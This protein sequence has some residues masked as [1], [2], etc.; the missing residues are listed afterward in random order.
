ME[1]NKFIQLWLIIGI[2]AGFAAVIFFVMTYLNNNVLCDLDCRFKNEV[3]LSLIFLSLVGMFIGSITYYFISEKYEK[4]LG[5]LHKDLSSTYKFLNP[6]QRA[7]LKSI[8]SKEG[9]TTQSDIVKQTRFSRVKVSR[10]LNQL[11]QKD[12][13]KKSQK[14]MTNEIMLSKDIKELFL[15]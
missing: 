10:C 5:K 2:I 3:Q 15:D 8:V 6:E 11:Q 7:V 9:K 1:R 13:I 12:I 4:R 14:G